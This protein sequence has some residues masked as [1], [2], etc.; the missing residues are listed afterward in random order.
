MDSQDKEKV[1]PW[2]TIPIIKVHSIE[3]L[4]FVL[5]G[6]TH[7]SKIKETIKEKWEKI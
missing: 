7:N 5:Y 3:L 2:R 4:F 6:I 1:G